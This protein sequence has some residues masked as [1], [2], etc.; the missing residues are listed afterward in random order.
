M[1]APPSTAPHSEI[2]TVIG[3]TD[4]LSN[5]AFTLGKLTYP[6]ESAQNDHLNMLHCIFYATQVFSVQMPVCCVCSW[7]S[8]NT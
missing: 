8:I 1:A 3:T 7:V 2:D 6:S 5:T 4:C